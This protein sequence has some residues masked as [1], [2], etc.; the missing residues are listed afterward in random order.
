MRAEV[1]FGELSS[2]RT[3]LARRAP[4]RKV[5]LGSSGWGGWGL[6]GRPG[7]GR[8]QICHKGAP[9]RDRPRMKP[10]NINVSSRSL[11][12]DRGLCGRFGQLAPPRAPWRTVARL[13]EVHDVNT[14]VGI[15]TE[16]GRR[17][18]GRPVRP[19]RPHKSAARPSRRHP[20]SARSPLN[21]RERTSSRRSHGLPDDLEGYPAISRTATPIP[22]RPAPPAV[23]H[24]G[25]ASRMSR[26]GRSVWITCVPLDHHIP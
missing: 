10:R 14:G 21:P 19:R 18:G 7:R 1:D 20:R 15:R 4:V 12:P 2:H 26:R 11:R 17:P 5:I 25:T 16:G 24:G 8:V 22:G 13:G 23:P 3:S 9:R 6:W